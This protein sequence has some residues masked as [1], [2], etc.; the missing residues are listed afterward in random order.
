MTNRTSVLNLLRQ[1]WNTLVPEA[2][3]RGIMIRPLTTRRESIDHRRTKLAWLR[4][5]LGSSGSFDTLTFGVEIEFIA[6]RGTSRQQVADAIT[7]AGI[8]CRNEH[9]NHVTGSGRWKIVQDGSLGDYTRGSE[10]VSPPLQGEAGFAELRKVMDV[11]TRLRCKITKKCGFHVHVGAASETVGFFKNLVKLY[12]S[13]EDAIDSFV[14]PSR[15]LSNNPYCGSLKNRIRSTSAI[16]TATNV[17][18]VAVAIRQTTGAANVRDH[19]RYCKLNLKSFWQHGTVEFRQHQGTVE[20][21]K[22]ENWVRL[23]LRLVLTA[24]AGEKQVT[25]FDDLMTA[26]DA[27]ESEK[28]YFRSRVNFFQ[29]VSNQTRVA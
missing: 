11:L 10:V 8:P 9:Y 20:G 25:T 29:S 22:A 27:S 6:P 2:R 16:D 3:A 15:R 19:T 1:E 28:N 21:Q 24:K 23:C 18:E 13:A 7:A 5:Q 14:A 26:V 17:A 12:A 4:A